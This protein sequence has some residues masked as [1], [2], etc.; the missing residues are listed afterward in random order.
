MKSW[1][2][3]AL[4]ASVGVFAGCDE[5]TTPGGDG[6]A[7]GETGGQTT[8]TGT[9]TG[10]GGA[11]T[12]GAGTGGQ[13]TG[14]QGTGGTATTTNTETT[15]NTTTGGSCDGSGDCQ[16]CQECATAPGGTCEASLGVCAA[17]QACVDLVNCVNGCK[18]DQ[19]CGQ[20]C[21]DSNP[22]G[23]E[24]FNAFASCVFEDACPNDCN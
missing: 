15:T 7:G 1:I 18:G 14:G 9:D 12:G 22:N 24:D 21:G 17:N 20:A 11:G 6:G 10:T 8:T 13:G 2:Y 3:V 23:V 19:V 16:G 4:I 5:D